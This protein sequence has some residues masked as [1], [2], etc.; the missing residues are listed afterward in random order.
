M[1]EDL[2]LWMFPGEC[3]LLGELGKSVIIIAS[4]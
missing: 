3:L 1:E 2:D 4:C